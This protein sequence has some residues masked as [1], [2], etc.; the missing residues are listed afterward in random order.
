MIEFSNEEYS[1]F[2]K[3]SNIPWDMLKNKTIFVSGATGLIG[4]A[5]IRVLSYMDKRFDLGCKIIAGVRD[6]QKAKEMLP[7]QI[8]LVFS[9]LESPICVDEKVDYIV[10]AACPT[11]SSFMISN[12][13]ELI[14]TSIYGTMNL[15]ELA[16]DNDASFL[17]LSSMEV[18]GEIKDEEPLGECRLGYI[19]PLVIRNCYPE[20]KRMCEN[21]IASYASQFGINA[22]SIRLAQ[23]IGPGISYNDGRVFAMMARCAIENK[24]IV[25]RTKGES[26]H[27]YLYVYDAITAIL[28]ALLCGH[29]GKSYNAGNSKTYCSIFEMGDMVIGT[30]GNNSCR[31]RIEESNSGAYPV[32]SYLNLDCREL[33]ALGWKPIYDLKEI[34]ENLII[35]M[36]R[37]KAKE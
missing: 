13:V 5:L 18:Y 22:K 19:D 26:K 23:T 15:L 14:K 36:K 24:D 11:Q 6:S 30:F 17:Y 32:P 7:E 16:K 8:T 12:P 27:P 20:S 21:I 29:A 9:A 34:Y 31:V 10:H 2:M 1:T 25:L 28:V 3:Q 4:S 33:E 35:Y 37:I